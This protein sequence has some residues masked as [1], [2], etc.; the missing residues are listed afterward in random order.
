MTTSYDL[1]DD[2]IPTPKRKIVKKKGKLASSLSETSPPSRARGP[3]MYSE[4]PAGSRTAP[5]TL[6]AGQREAFDRLH[7]VD[8]NVFLTGAAGSG[9]SHLVREFLKSQDKQKFPVI[10]STGAAAILVGGRTF[11]SFFGLGIMEGGY[12]ETVD[13]AV[14]HWVV[15]R[16]LKE[17]H[18]VII[19][20]ISMISG[21]ALR[22]AEEISRLARSCGDRPWGGLKVIVVGDFS[23]LPPVNRMGQPRDWAFLDPVWSESGFV[24][25]SLSEP[26]RTQDPEFLTILNRIRTGIVDAD[27]QKFLASR[28][29]SFEA[30][31]SAADNTRAQ[32]TT[33][34]FPRRDRVDAY[35][36]ACLEKLDGPIFTQQTSYF[37]A[38][39]K[40]LEDIKRNAPVGETLTLKEGAL[41]MLRQNDPEQRFVNGSL[42]IVRD[43]K[44][45]CLSIE[46]LSGIDVEI[47]PTSFSLLDGDGKEQASARNFPVN[48]AYACTIHKAQGMTLDRM[49]VD[50]AGAWEHGQAY[51]ALS[52][53]RTGKSL[54]LDGW[55]PRSIVIDSA[56]TGFYGRTGIE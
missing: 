3:A 38:D 39:P 56:V 25:T 5:L 47:E 23:Q 4:R 12:Q 7:A 32:V 51:V 49:R 36:L 45:T 42:G 27:V 17:I 20:E 52:R 22:A 18:G 43:M 21:I 1:F 16:R 30:K 9:K 26:M 41:V 50:L 48:L 14:K 15:S 13:R 46:L 24:T 37:S 6:N 55:S 54:E 35:N 33:R 53:V 34:L 40:R 10:A 29:L 2:E 28:T 8:T 31:K 19:D 44:P 11:H